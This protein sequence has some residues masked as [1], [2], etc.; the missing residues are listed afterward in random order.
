MTLVDFHPIYDRQKVQFITTY[1]CLKPYSVE[2]NFWFGHQPCSN[3]DLSMIIYEW[4]YNIPAVQWPKEAGFRVG[5]NTPY[6]YVIIHI[7]YSQSIINDIYGEQITMTRTRP[8]YKIGTYQI[9]TNKFAFQSRSISLYRVRHHELQSIFK[10]NLHWP[11]TFYQLPNSIDIQAND[12]LIGTCIYEHKPSKYLRYISSDLI[13]QITIMFWMDQEDDMPTEECWNNDFSQILERYLPNTADIPPQTLYDINPIY[14]KLTPNEWVIMNENISTTILKSTNNNTNLLFLTYSEI[15]FRQE[16]I[17]FVRRYRNLL[18]IIL[19]LILIV[20]IG[21]LIFIIIINRIPSWKKKEYFSRNK[22]RSKAIA[23]GG[24]TSSLS[25]WLTKR[26]FQQYD[27][28]NF[29]H[30]ESEP[31]TYKHRWASSSEET[32]ISDNEVF[33]KTDFQNVILKN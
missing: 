10:G 25:E 17:H 24:E 26:R 30:I 5:T 31:L 19:I 29:D 21:L 33:N 1:L 16:I 20:S 11:Q 32:D 14:P 7:K 15:T 8:K 3:T 4:Y 27:Q 2:E 12:Y 6:R 28:D 22:T 13:C 23:V 18:L 9:A